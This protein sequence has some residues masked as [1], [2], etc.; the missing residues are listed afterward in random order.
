MTKVGALLVGPAVGPLSLP[1]SL[2]S[3]Q[4]RLREGISRSMKDGLR[5]FQVTDTGKLE[6]DRMMGMVV[7]MDPDRERSGRRR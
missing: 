1:L 7:R 2:P 4:A 5:G 3:T 6:R